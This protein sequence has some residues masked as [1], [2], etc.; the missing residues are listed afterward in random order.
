MFSG[1]S[2]QI[3][4][5]LGDDELTDIDATVAQGRYPSRAAAVRAGIDLLLRAERDRRIA[6]EYRRAH[7]Q[8]PDEA[9]VGEAG[10]RLGADIISDEER[11][12]RRHRR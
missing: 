12:R 4:I 11:E 8:S 2:Q 9:A 5:R 10:L 3:A 6:E 7:G 1:M